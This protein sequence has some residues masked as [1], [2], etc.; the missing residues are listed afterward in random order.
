M[1][2]LNDSLSWLSGFNEKIPTQTIDNML[3]RCNCSLR[4]MRRKIKVHGLICSYNKNSAFYTVPNL[5]KFNRY[6]I[7]HHDSASFSKWGN[8]YETIIQLIDQSEMGFTSGEL[9]SVLKIRVYD[10][11]RVLSE[12]KQIEKK[13]IDSKNVYVSTKADL[14]QAQII[15]RKLSVKQ[16]SFKLPEPDVI[17]AILLELLLGK[18]PTPRKICNKLMKK[19]ITI[20]AITI[21][22]VIDYYQLKKKLSI[23]SVNRF[24]P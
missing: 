13:E 14:R 20:T 17:I 16:D 5:V 18:L 11:L 6:G 4:T 22:K 10:P 8:L 7:W 23:K 15:K 9:K 2:S 21:E 24:D 12:K 3:N 19:G 1:P